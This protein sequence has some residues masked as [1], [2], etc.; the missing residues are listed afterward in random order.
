MMN[1]GAM[2]PA[3]PQALRAFHPFLRLQALLDAVPPGPSPLPGGAPVMLQVGEPQRQP[4]AFVADALSEAAAGWSRYP[5][6]RGVPDY[7]EAAAD[8]LRMR[9]RLPQAMLDP[10]RHLIAVPGTREGLFFA[11]LA[12]VGRKAEQSGDARRPAILLPNPFYH[13][14]CGAALM[15]GAEPVFVPAT[16]ESGFQPDYTRLPAEVLDRAALAFVCSPANPQGSVMPAE[17]MRGLVALAR[18]H[19]FAVAF[20]ECYCEIYPDSPPAGALQALAESGDHSLDNILVFHS[21]SKRS[22][23]AGLRCGVVAG[24]A[25]LIDALDTAMRLGGA[26]VPVPVAAAGARLW[27]DETHVEANRRVYRENFEAAWRIL[28]NRFD[29]RPPA[30]G[31]FL[32]LDVGDGEKAALELWREAGI[33]S[34]PGAYMAEDGPDGDNPGRPYLRLALV[35][36]RPVVETALTRVAEVL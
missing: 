23:A 28:G 1:G 3:G 13:V 36:D 35:Y 16:R 6:P 17:A 11:A 4:P 5:P 30:G 8:W 24:E 26:G 19:D 21:L 2:G 31:F 12:L 10:A 33:R 9:F 22:N 20:D 34:L 18:A 14:Y 29:A 27:R 15:S 32:W 25:A 7:L